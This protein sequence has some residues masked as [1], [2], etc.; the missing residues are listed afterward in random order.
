[1][2]EK[3][4]IRQQIKEKTEKL[5]TEYLRMSEEEIQRKVLTLPEFKK[6]ET[7]FCYVSAGREVS[8]N[9][10]LSECFRQGKRVGVPLCTAPGIM[11][12]REI[13]CMDQLE[14]GIYGLREPKRN[15]P[16]VEKK[17][18]DL[19]II[20]CVSAD[21]CGKRL[22]H[23]AG[24]YDRYLCDTDFLKVLLCRRKLLWNDIP[25]DSHDVP[26]DLVVTE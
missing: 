20:P 13:T 8:T 9:Q 12:V 1:M 5:S 10:I 18:I 6:A 24:Y 3:Q 4:R 2:E 19:G 25:S 17:E 21:L 7:V 22:G 11:E 26:M 23:G 16:P 14:D 15:T